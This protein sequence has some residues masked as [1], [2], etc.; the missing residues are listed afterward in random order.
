MVKAQCPHCGQ[1]V[2][3]ELEVDET[4][5][6]AAERVCN[7]EGAQRARKIAQSMEQANDNIDLEFYKTS[8][9]AAEILKAAVRPVGLGKVASVTVDT[10][11]GVKGI[12]K[13]TNKGTIRVSKVETKKVEHDE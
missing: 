9:A 1:Y 10:G 2:M 8:E 11:N 6:Q 12:I 3:V 5:E 7:C 4:E 13:A